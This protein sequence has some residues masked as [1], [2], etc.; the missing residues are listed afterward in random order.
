MENQLVKSQVGKW[1]VETRR[2]VILGL[3][4]AA[5]AIE[6]SIRDT[7]APLVIALLVAYLLNPL[8]TFVQTRARIARLGA[9]ALVYLVLVALIITALAT[10]VPLLIRQISG[11]ARGLDGILVQT[12]AAIKALPF[13]TMM[14]I[15]TDSSALAD[16]LRKQLGALASSAPDLVADVASGAFSLIFILVLSFY[17]LKDVAMIEQGIDGAIPEHYRDDAQRIK[18]E[19][20]EIWSSFLRG[21]VVL[22]LIIGTITTLVLWALGVRYALLLGVLAGLLEVVPT[23]GP[24]IAMV[25]AV[26]LALF[27]G[28]AHLPVDNTTFAL[29]IVATY[30]LIQQLENHLVVPNVLGSSVNLPAVVILFGA[31]AGASLG[32]V[33]GI[34]LAAPVLATARLFGRFLLKQL[35]A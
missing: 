6:Y 29:V 22:A 24:I 12:S 1:S 34:F 21:Q 18:T 26:L 10:L 30:F 7:I 33:L 16:Q 13:A 2:W 9:V 14:G 15:P 8:V 17:L 35:L 25:P 4:V 27:Q 28:S 11:L 19:L 31:F 23:I 5:V 20:N 3:V 32:G